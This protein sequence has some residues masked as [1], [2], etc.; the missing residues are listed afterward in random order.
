V[1]AGEKLLFPPQSQQVVRKTLD[2]LIHVA[3][4]N[5]SRWTL[6]LIGQAV[7]WLQRRSLVCVWKTLRRLGIV[8]KR[9]REYVHSP[10]PNYALKLAYVEAA[11]LQAQS[12]PERVVLL[13]EDEIT[14]YRRPTLSRGYALVGSTEP[15]ARLGYSV[16]KKRR[17]AGSL[18]SV[19]GQF[20][21][22]Q[23]AHFRVA[24]LI[25]YY[26]QL[27]GT[28]PHAK[29]IY[30]VQDNWPVHRHPQ[31]LNF[32]LTS[33]IVPLFLPTYAPWTNPTEKVWLRLKREVLHLHPFEDHWTDLIQAVE[34]WLAQWLS[35]S[36]DLLHFVGLFPS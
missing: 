3:P 35:P 34:R 4:Q 6:A 32:F 29:T 16:N 2:Q 19:T 23:R 28:Y 20:H 24:E 18:N 21:A 10:D 5:G 27:E 7:S 17:I 15:K 30:L 11:R 26:Q 8:Y 25:R 1:D 36:P 31:L 12:Q 14:Y 33:R 13:Y 22:Q 9:G